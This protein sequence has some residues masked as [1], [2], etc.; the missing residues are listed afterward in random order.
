MAYMAVGGNL[1]ALGGF[2]CS[3]VVM[4]IIL[5]SDD[6]SRNVKSDTKCIALYIITNY[7][8]VEDYQCII[9]ANIT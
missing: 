7:Y 3:Y 6:M 4:I 9:G 5:C 1:L 2:Y 8:T